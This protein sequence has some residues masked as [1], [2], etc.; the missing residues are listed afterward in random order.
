MQLS[1]NFAWEQNRAHSRDAFT[2]PIFCKN[3]LLFIQLPQLLQQWHSCMACT[4]HRD[5]CDWCADHGSLMLP[6]ASCHATL[7]AP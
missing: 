1:D 6:T 4:D 7:Q 2:S 5:P 3:S